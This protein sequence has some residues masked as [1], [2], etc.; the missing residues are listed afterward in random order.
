[1]FYID[2]Q[3]HVKNRKVRDVFKELEGRSLYIKVLG[4]YPMESDLA[5]P[6]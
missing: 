5:E 6:G 4:S 3:G 1:M 2:F